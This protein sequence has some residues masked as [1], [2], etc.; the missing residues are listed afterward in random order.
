MP[1][2]INRSYLKSQTEALAQVL[3]H[4]TELKAHRLAGYVANL[5]FWLGEITRT[6]SNIDGY[7]QRFQRM[8][9]AT[10]SFVA[11][12]PGQHGSDNRTTKVVKDKDLKELRSILQQSTTRFILRCL[13]SGLIDLDCVEDAEKKLGFRMRK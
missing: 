13:N 6:M 7:E 3:N 2:G 10:A 5:D 9:Q 8:R 11:T 4:A 12:H 1:K